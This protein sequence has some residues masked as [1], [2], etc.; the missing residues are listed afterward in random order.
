MAVVESGSFRRAAEKVFRTQPAISQ[1]I[2]KLEEEVGAPLFARDGHEVALTEAGKLLASYAKRMLRLRADTYHALGELKNLG[3]GSVSIAA[4]ESA[5][6]YLLPGPLQCFFER[7]PGVKLGIYRRHRDEIAQQVMDRE[8]DI[9]F[10]LSEPSFHE[11]ESFPIYEDVMT[12][13]ASPEHPLAGRS[14]V[15]IKDLGRERFV[16]HHGCEPTL[17]ELEKTFEENGNR[18]AI[19]AELWGFESVKTFVRQGLGLAIVPRLTAAE[20][21]R[22]GALAEIPVLGL[23]MPRRTFLICRDPRYLTDAARALLETVRGFNWGALERKTGV[24][25]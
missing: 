13:I 21:L 20:E 10:V 17:Q 12:L 7:Y 8:I 11:M 2:K 6:L 25:R 16:L 24:I 15:A 23:Q 18:L 19:T 22:H 3:S 9:G 14:D 4:P 5:A 1:S